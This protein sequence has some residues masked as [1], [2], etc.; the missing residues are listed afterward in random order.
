MLFMLIVQNACFSI[1]MY[2]Y[3]YMYIYAKLYLYALLLHCVSRVTVKKLTVDITLLL[4]NF[5]FSVFNMC[6]Q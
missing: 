3:V 2:I 6:Y 4:Q 5:S 1:I